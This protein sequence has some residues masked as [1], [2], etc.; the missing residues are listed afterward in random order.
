[1]RGQPRRKE[2]RWFLPVSATRLRGY[3]CY[4]VRMA[5]DI[6]WSMVGNLISTTLLRQS[7]TH[8][9]KFAMTHVPV[10]HANEA[11]EVTVQA[12][13]SDTNLWAGLIG[14]Q[15]NQAVMRTRSEEIKEGHLGLKANLVLSGG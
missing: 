9:L 1:M 12:A 7:R 15:H 13:S 11:T 4:H 2:Q 14:W 3:C 8:E 6:G 5:W 10:A